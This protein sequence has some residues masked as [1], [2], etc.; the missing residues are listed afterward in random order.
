MPIPFVGGQCAH[1]CNRK[2]PILFWLLPTGHVKWIGMWI[3]IH[4]TESTVP[5]IWLSKVNVNYRKLRWIR[6]QDRQ[7]KCDERDKTI[8]KRSTSNNSIQFIILIG[9]YFK[10]CP[11]NW[12]ADAWEA[13]LIFLVRFRQ[14]ALPVLCQVRRQSSA[15]HWFSASF[16]SQYNS[17]PS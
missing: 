1:W 3:N 15:A 17:C 9:M 7:M 4:S 8:T 14:L 6:R 5:A 11:M 2:L 13:V 16:F 10:F 12:F